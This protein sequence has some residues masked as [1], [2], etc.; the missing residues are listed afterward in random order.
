MSDKDPASETGDAPRRGPGPLVS[1]LIDGSGWVLG[2]LFGWLVFGDVAMGALFAV[3]F[4]IAT[5]VGQR[6]IKR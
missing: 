4:G 5:G 1:G 2:F 6:S 3:L